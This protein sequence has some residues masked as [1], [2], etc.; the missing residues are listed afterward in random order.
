MNITV[1]CGSRLGARASYK[2]IAV[3]LG[4]WIGENGHALVYGG[5][6]VGMMG[7]IAEATL[8]AG[9]EVYGVIPTV[10]MDQELG[11]ND[12][13][14]LEIVDS[15]AE[16][17]QRMIEL[18]DAFIA[19]PGGIGTMEEITEIMTQKKIGLSD[20]PCIFMNIEGYYDKFK[21]FLE[22]M[23]AEDF[24]S[25]R[26]CGEIKFAGS[27]EEMAEILGSGINA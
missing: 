11:K 13:T 14:R 21:D 15:M 7:A 20:A 23:I 22:F 24:Y 4:T 3:D 1:Y 5:G 2:K 6:D 25:Q 19:L 9:G 18:G 17:K 10:L 16:R 27:L 12:V 8:A 26:D